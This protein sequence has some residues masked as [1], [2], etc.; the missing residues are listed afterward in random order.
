MSELALK[1][2]DYAIFVAM[3][4]VVFLVVRW[5]LKRWR[6]WAS[7]PPATWLI[8]SVVLLAGWWPVE[9]S[10]EAERRQIE[11]LVSALAPTY[12]QELARS[13]HSLIELDTQDDNP[14]LIAIRRSLEDWN[15]NNTMASDIYTMRL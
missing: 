4:I 5:G 8:M 13:G 11:Q 12:A 6:S 2:A 7:L 10:G 1:Q 3:T 9:Q 15:R 14:V